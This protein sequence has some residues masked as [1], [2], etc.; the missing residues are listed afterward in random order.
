[1]RNHHWR[2]GRFLAVLFTTLLLSGILSAC[3]IQWITPVPEMGTV[4]PVEETA[5][6]EPEQITP[7]PSPA[8]PTEAPAEASEQDAA[9]EDES[10]GNGSGT[11]AALAHALA[12]HEGCIDC[13]AVDSRREPAPANHVGMTDNICL[14]CHMPEEGEAAIPPLPSKAEPEFC[15]GCH[16]PYEALLALTEGYAHEDG[17]E[18]N[19]HIS[20][21]HGKDTPSGCSNC[22]DVHAL[23]V[24]A[25]VEIKEANLTYCYSACHHEENFEPC[26]DCHEE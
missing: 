6:V 25:E 2:A 9:A 23:P 4:Q 16:G 15:L 3:T 17:V 14:Y 10:K 12:R 24:T 11:P 22:H 20:I 13:H 5:T 21:P 19:P 1:M 18:A 26:S 8:A 7:M